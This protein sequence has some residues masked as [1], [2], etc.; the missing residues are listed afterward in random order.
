[1]NRRVVLVGALLAVVPLAAQIGT[2]RIRVTTPYGDDI[3][4][5]TAS[6]LGA[7]CQPI[8]T[9]SASDAGEILL[10]GIPLGDSHFIVTAPGF[11][12]VRVRATVRGSNKENVRAT[13]NVA[14]IEDVPVEAL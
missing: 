8:R 11:G 6:L 14:P 2:V 9:A 3:P 4:T 1:V 13:L 7:G 5:A 12:V 10:A